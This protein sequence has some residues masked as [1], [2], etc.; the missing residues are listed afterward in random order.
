MAK[1][2]STSIRVPDDVREMVE[3]LKTRFRLTSLSAVLWYCVNRVYRD[4]QAKDGKR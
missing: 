2:Q 1:L 4:E 3:Y